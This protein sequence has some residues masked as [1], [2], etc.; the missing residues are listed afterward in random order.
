MK[1]KVCV[2][3]IVEEAPAEKVVRDWCFFND[4]EPDFVVDWEVDDKGGISGVFNGEADYLPFDELKGGLTSKSND[5]TSRYNN[6]EYLG[7]GR[8]RCYYRRDIEAEGVMCEIKE[9]RQECGC[10]S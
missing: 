9:R 8:Y 4:A 1:A 3:E 5:H 10:S 7:G 2:V 6:L